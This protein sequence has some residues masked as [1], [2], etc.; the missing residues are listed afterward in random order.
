[1]VVPN[2]SLNNEEVCPA[3]ALGTWLSKPGEVEEAVKYAI[4]IGYR[5][6]DCAWL[7]GNEKEIG[8]AIRAKLADETVHRNELFITTK[9]WNTFHEEE[10]VVE[11]C[12]RSLKNF[13]LCYV[14]LYL[15]HWPCAQKNLGKV[16]FNLPFKDAVNIPYDFVK[17]WRGMERCVELKLAKSIGLSNFNSKQVQRIL[18]N[19]KIK[20]VMNQIEV[21]PYFNNKQLIKFCKERQLAIQGYSPLGSPARPWIKPGDPV[22]DLKTP[23]VEGIGKK[24]GKTGPQVIL[25]YV[26]QLGVIPIPKSSNFERLKQ[27]IDIFDFELS[28]EDMAVM[29]SLNINVRACHAEELKDSPDY[30]FKENE[31]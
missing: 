17:T 16:D 2:I 15:V 21:N 24:Y 19:C 10:E 18:D 3:L 20:P 31:F 28:E 1:M 12:K 9:L 4:D 8:N 29:D 30:P 6:I 13:G 14:D 5:H 23:E 22:V 27:N 7:Y 11:A 25:R 26:Y